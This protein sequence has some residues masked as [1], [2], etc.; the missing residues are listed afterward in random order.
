MTLLL[1][2]EPRSFNPSSYNPKNVIRIEGPLMKHP[3]TYR[4]GFANAYVFGNLYKLSEYYLHSEVLVDHGQIGF[5]NITEKV[6]LKPNDP[7]FWDL[8]YR[9]DSWFTDY[10][11]SMLLR[12][13][14]DKCPQILWV[15]NVIA[16]DIVRLY[17]HKGGKSIIVDNSFFYI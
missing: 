8:I 15:G 14:Q 6:F 17:I 12:I 11:D 16:S 2:V 1:F 13:L 9:N 3:K 7:I 10:N 5:I 4:C